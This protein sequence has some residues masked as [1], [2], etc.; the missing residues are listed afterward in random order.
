MGIISP[1]Q[2]V[3]LNCKQEYVQDVSTF[4]QYVVLIPMVKWF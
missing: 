2:K 4:R 1:E 3:V